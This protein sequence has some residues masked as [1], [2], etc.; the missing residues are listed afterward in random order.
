VP[1]L[2]LVG[3]LT[4]QWKVARCRWWLD[5]PV[6]NSGRLK[7]LILK[8]A[9]EHGWNWQVDLV[10]NP[11]KVLAQTNQVVATADSAILDQCARWVNLTRCV[12]DSRVGGAKLLDLSVL[13]PTPP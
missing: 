10:M 2:Q 6:S 1:A 4:C 12:I 11:D 13:E 3:E 8:V 7:T 9:A 5:Q